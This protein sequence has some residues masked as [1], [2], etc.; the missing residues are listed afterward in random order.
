MRDINREYKSCSSCLVIKALVDFYKHSSTK[1]K[2]GTECRE[3]YKSH[4]RVYQRGYDRI[5]HKIKTYYS[6][7]K[8][9]IKFINFKHFEK[10]YDY[11]INLNE[12]DLCSSKFK[13]TRDRQ[14]EHIHLRVTNNIRGVVCLKC[15][16]ELKV[17]DNRRKDLLLELHKY[18]I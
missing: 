12:C 11:Y 5:N 7:N 2:R 13:S 4:R 16:Q 9:G 14:L 8:Q 15:N 1:D 17:L 18:F 6:W 3:C 10:V